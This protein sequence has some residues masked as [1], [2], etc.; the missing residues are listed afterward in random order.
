MYSQIQIELNKKVGLR[1]P[2]NSKNKIDFHSRYNQ[3]YLVIFFLFILIWC[4]GII[5]PTIFHSEKSFL[6]A[7]P[8]L[9]QVYSTVCHQQYAKTISIGGESIFVC[10]RCAG[11]YIGLLLASAISLFIILRIKTFNFLLLTVVLLLLDVTLSSY[12]IYSYSKVLA[13]LTGFLFSSAIFLF[14]IDE[15]RNYQSSRN[16][17]T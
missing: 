4:I 12:K 9:N 13:S 8:F 14:F 5:S 2:A 3:K 15:M 6:I 17:E 16:Y 10:S 11:I 7:K 1:N